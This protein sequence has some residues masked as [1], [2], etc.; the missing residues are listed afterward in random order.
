MLWRGVGERCKC[1]GVCNVCGAMCANAV[2][3]CR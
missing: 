3:Q 2:A 1:S